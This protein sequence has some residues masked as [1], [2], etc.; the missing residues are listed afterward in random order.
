MS[1]FGA[2]FSGARAAVAMVA[3]APPTLG[4]GT[5]MDAQLMLPLIDMAQWSTNLAVRPTPTPS[6]RAATRP[7]SC[8]R[9]RRSDLAR[10]SDALAPPPPVPPKTPPPPIPQVK[11][12]AVSGLAVMAKS[13]ANKKM[14]GTMGALEALVQLL[15]KSEE[16]P[17]SMLT[18][19]PARSARRPGAKAPGAKTPGAKTPSRSDPTTLATPPPPAATGSTPTSSPLV[20]DPAPPARAKVGDIPMT[21]LAARGVA[22]LLSD[23]DNQDFFVRLGGLEKTY[24]LVAATNNVDIRASLASALADLA[25]RPE[26]CAAIVDTGGLPAVTALAESPDVKVCLHAVSCARRLSRL[27]HC[28]E[29]WSPECLERLLTWLTAFAGHDGLCGMTVECVANLCDDSDEHRTRVVASGGVPKIAKFLNVDRYEDDVRVVAAR[30]LSRMAKNADARPHLAIPA[31][32]GSFKRSVEANAAVANAEQLRNTVDTVAAL[33]DCDAN[34]KKLA[35]AGYAETLFRA[36]ATVRDK[37]LRRLCTRVLGMIARDESCV[38]VFRPHVAAVV[39]LMAH[40]DPETQLHAATLAAA[41]TRDESC[42]RDVNRSVARVAGLLKLW[43]ESPDGEFRRAALNLGSNLVI[44]PEAKAEMMRGAAPTL[45]AFMSQSRSKDP[46][47]QLALAGFLSKLADG[48]DEI[49]AG[50]VRAG[51]VWR[52]KALRD[53]GK[54][55]MARQVAAATLNNQMGKHFAAIRIQARFR[56]IL[57]RLRERRREREAAIEAA[58]I[59]AEKLEEKIKAAA[60]VS[61]YGGGANRP[62]QPGGGY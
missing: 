41:L 36:M 39:E 34:R 12:D 50:L 24:G 5:P 55:V 33:A 43:A 38:G 14:M 30:C 16:N 8:G 19:S 49:K 13:E 53:D 20:S 6:P 37:Q 21:R 9:I 27:K 26:Y 62:N 15:F 60:G 54:H 45:K 51:A 40:D 32:L 56:G 42:R 23:F 44:E 18:D 59:A 52:L 1:L 3:S 47:V 4:V 25:R 7:V 29:R 28:R 31:V 48:D 35:E 57:H 17:T 46:E 11:R 22:S 10:V 61:A 2:H 58:R